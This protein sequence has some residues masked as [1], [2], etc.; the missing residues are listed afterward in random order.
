MA[1]RSRPN[2]NAGT[3]DPE[4]P[5][6]N[7]YSLLSHA[8]RQSHDSACWRAIIVAAPLAMP[9]SSANAKESVR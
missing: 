7:V 9:M 1:D 3:A 5:V 2:I 4:L 6:T 8:C